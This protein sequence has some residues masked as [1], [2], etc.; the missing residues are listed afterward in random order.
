MP[1]L[2]RGYPRTDGRLGEA[3]SLD[4]AGDVL[5]L[6]DGDEDAELIE[7]H[8]VNL[9]RP[10]LQAQGSFDGGE[11][12]ERNFALAAGVDD[13]QDQPIMENPA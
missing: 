1:P 10:P 7:R 2:Q 4:R 3:Q 5:P 11:R 13:V 6:G 8:I 9:R 12:S